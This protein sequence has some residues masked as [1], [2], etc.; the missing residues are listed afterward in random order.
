MERIF[1]ISLLIFHC[2]YDIRL[3]PQ[4]KPKFYQ[5]LL[6]Y[7]SELNTSV[8]DSEI[9]VW[10]NIPILTVGKSVFCKNMFDIGIIFVGDLFTSNNRPIPFNFSETKK[11]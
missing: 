6:S 1:F 4:N 8:P 9:I 11:P 5:E 10:N 7:W 2:N 3:F